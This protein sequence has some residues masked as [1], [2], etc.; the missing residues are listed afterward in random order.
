MHRSR[1]AGFI[2]DYRDTSPD[3][4]ATFWSAALGLPTMG[5]AEVARLGK[6]GARGLRRQSMTMPLPCDRPI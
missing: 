4:A 5:K 2:I 3:S 1:L 6:L